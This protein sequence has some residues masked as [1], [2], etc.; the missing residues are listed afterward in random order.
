MTLAPL[1]TMPTIGLLKNRR[2]LV[3]VP[4]DVTIHTALL[5]C[6]PRPRRLAVQA[7]SGAALTAVSTAAA[8]EPRRIARHQ[9]HSVVKS[10]RRR[11]PTGLPPSSRALSSLAFSSAETMF[12]GSLGPG[13]VVGVGMKIPGTNNP[14]AGS[15][16]FVTRSRIRFIVAI[17]SVT[18]IGV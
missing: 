6:P 15:G 8:S 14:L 12:S 10:S 13:L 1:P 17:G 4:T 16:R 9:S 2:N 5:L 3:G 18:T 11:C 7:H